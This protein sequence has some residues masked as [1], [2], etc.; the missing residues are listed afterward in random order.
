MLLHILG[1]HNLEQE[2][3][4][5][6]ADVV[7]LGATARRR[8]RTVDGQDQIQAQAQVQQQ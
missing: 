6:S 2:R 7:P 1:K 5:E 8:E 3:A 4:H